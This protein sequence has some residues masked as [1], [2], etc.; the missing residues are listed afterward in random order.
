[1]KLTANRGNYKYCHKFKKITMKKNY[2]VI[3]ILILTMN[4]F[5][6]DEYQSQL[7]SLND[8]LNL[9]EKTYLLKKKVDNKFLSDKLDLIK[10]LHRLGEESELA[11]IDKKLNIE[12]SDLLSIVTEIACNRL[13]FLENYLHYKKELYKTNYDRSKVIYLSL[14]LKVKALEK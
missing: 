13:N 1:M 3:C 4:C 6:Q 9:L 12:L 14:Y 7:Y 5:A 8:R 10:D 2:L 11:G